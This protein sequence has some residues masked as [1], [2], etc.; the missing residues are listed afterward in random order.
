[1]ENSIE[2]LRMKKLRGENK[3]PFLKEQSMHTQSM[4]FISSPKINRRAKKQEDEYHPTRTA[5]ATTP[6]P[7]SRHHLTHHRYDRI[8]VV[9]G[10]TYR[11][12]SSVDLI[13]V[14]RDYFQ[15]PL[16]TTT[17][18]DRVCRRIKHVCV[19]LS[20]PPE[21][22]GST[23]LFVDLVLATMKVRVDLLSVMAMSCLHISCELR[24]VEVDS[25]SV[26]EAFLQLQRT[27]S[28]RSNESTESL[29]TTTSTAT[30][31]STTSATSA[32]TIAYSEEKKESLQLSPP[33]S[34][35]SSSN[36]SCSASSDEEDSVDGEDIS[37]EISPSKRIGQIK[38]NI[39][40][41]SDGNSDSEED[42]NDDVFTQK[43]CDDVQ[44]MKALVSHKLRPFMHMDTAHDLVCRYV[45]TMCISLLPPLTQCH[46]ILDDIPE[47]AEVHFSLQE[48]DERDAVRTIAVRYA[49][50]YG[51][52]YKVV[53]TCCVRAY[54]IACIE[55]AILQIYQSPQQCEA[56]VDGLCD[57]EKVDLK[58]LQ[59]AQWTSAVSS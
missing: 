36:T 40:S 23:Y 11:H 19:R 21:V 44:R 52:K 12:N 6:T 55:A 20:L 2:M 57:D 18:R 24:G 29:Q 16:V 49:S 28:R 48:D 22:V 31:I 45:D 26:C 58:T 47:D 37:G 34:S 43:L 32:V 13:W 51:E 9:D 4:Q 59:Y 54:A 39:H 30:S 8:A 33:S 14:A 17:E 7:L 53:S 27:R 46:S 10:R 38:E 50:A 5:V 56:V 42:E 25:T 41:H 1:M 15:Q 35:S 3:V